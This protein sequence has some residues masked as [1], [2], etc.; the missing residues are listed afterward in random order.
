MFVGARMAV[1]TGIVRDERYLEHKPGHMHP[2]HPNRLKAVYKMLDSS[3][4]GG[5]IEIE[6]EPATLEQIEL[7]HS[8]SYIKKVLKT[9]DHGF[10]SLAPDTPA[11]ARTYLSAWLAV[12]GCLKALDT[13]VSGECEAC[14]SLVRPP[15]HHALRDRAGGFCIF[16]NLGITARYAVKRYDFKRI[17]IIDWDIHHGNG[18]NDTFYEEKRVLYISSHDIML[19]PYTGDWEE[20]GKGEGEGY[21]INI[22][23]PRTL[24]DRDFFFLYQEIV[25]DVIRAYNPQ[26]VLVG[27]GFD[28]HSEDP[29]GRSR[30]S[31]KT[32]RW[33]THLLLEMRELIDHPPILL[34]LEGG[35]N[36]RALASC[37]KEVLDALKCDTTWERPS[38]KDALQGAELVEKVHRIHEHYGVW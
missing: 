33:L 27:A 32:F 31:Q 19:Y 28:A 8:P 26:L 2:E 10:T 3:F 35:Y 1:K 13:L 21:T 12:G 37:V 24:K 38:L 30:L 18:L 17:L 5:L 9:A 34:V 25:G 22:P 4:P 14:L 16:N 7:V 29:V 15:G 20:T 11:S 36:P 23:I 6:P